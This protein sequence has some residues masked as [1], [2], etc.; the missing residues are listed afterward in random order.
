MNRAS[1][2][3]DSCFSDA[4]EIKHY[5]V[6][7]NHERS[8]LKNSRLRSCWDLG[9]RGPLE[10]KLISIVNSELVISG[11]SMGKLV[12][13]VDH[14]F[15]HLRTEPTGVIEPSA[16][17]NPSCLDRTICHFP[18]RCGLNVTAAFAL[19]GYFNSAI[20]A[21]LFY[22]LRRKGITEVPMNRLRRFYSHTSGYLRI[23]VEPWS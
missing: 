4:A 17:A 10:R 18:P 15:R 21:A 9:W 20:R 13:S 11:S 3:L 2:L 12:W 23:Y 7:C 8:T 1:L 16:P 22:A 6:H 5:L 14:I 19:K